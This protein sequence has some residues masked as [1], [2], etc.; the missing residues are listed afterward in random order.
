MGEFHTA[1][2]QYIAKAAPFARPILEH[3]R[4]VV[5]K[6]CPQVEEKIK[7]GMPF[8]DYKGTMM[9][10][11]A[12][13]KAH[14]AMGFWYGSRLEDPK[15]H[16]EKKDAAAMGHLGRV[17]SIKDLPPAKELTSFIKQ[18]MEMTNMGVKL[19]T[20]KKAPPKALKLPADF[21]AA[22]GKNKKAQTHWTAFPPGK[23]NEYINW[24]TEAKSAATRTKRLATAIAQISEGKS[25]NW[26][27][28]KK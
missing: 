7:W 24:I 5:H 14:C 17:T 20:T 25:K 27:Y 8:F 12:A 10:H 19:T 23:R 22:L 28:E 16:L 26:K 15:G 18:S 1:V 3:I 9:C 21:S 11:M 4:A 13:F 2:D 6:A